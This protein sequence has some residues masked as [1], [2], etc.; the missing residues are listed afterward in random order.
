M[1]RPILR[2]LRPGHG[3]G[4]SFGWS[5][6]YHPKRGSTNHLGWIISHSRSA[7]GS[8]AG[9][10]GEKE[11]RSAEAATLGCVIAGEMPRAP[12]DQTIFVGTEAPRKIKFAIWTCT[13]LQTAS[14]GTKRRAMYPRRESPKI[15]TTCTRKP[16]PSGRGDHAFSTSQSLYSACWGTSSLGS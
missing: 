9:A 2:S 15:T 5:R 13:V 8:A 6:S 14:V 4:G 12:S 3:L 16:K 7:G 10:G 1:L 11:R